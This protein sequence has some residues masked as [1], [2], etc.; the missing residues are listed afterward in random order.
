MLLNLFNVRNSH[1][2]DVLRALLVASAESISCKFSIFNQNQHTLGIGLPM[3]F[4]WPK[5]LRLI[6]S[7]DLIVL[8]VTTF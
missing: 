6:E 8:L 4:G 3:F 5:T 2:C 7:G 1:R